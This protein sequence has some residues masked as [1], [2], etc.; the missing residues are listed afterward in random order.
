MLLEARR[1]M[2]LAFR[3]NGFRRF[4]GTLGCSLPALRDR[5]LGSLVVFILGRPLLSRLRVGL[6]L[7][8]SE[9]CFGGRLRLDLVTAAFEDLQRHLELLRLERTEVQFARE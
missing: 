7:R 2:A 3:G 5:F 8:L 4:R 6:G 9:F 1:V